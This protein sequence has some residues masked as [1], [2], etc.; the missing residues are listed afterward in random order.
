M[1]GSRSAPVTAS[2]LR[3]S[4]TPTCS[5]THLPR[6]PQVYINGRLIGGAEELEHY[7][8]KAA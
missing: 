6:L 4:A 1:E 5:S 7:L 2:P 3:E 8:K